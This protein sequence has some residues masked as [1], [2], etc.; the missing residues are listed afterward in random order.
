MLVLLRDLLQQRLVQSDDLK[1]KSLV[2]LTPKERSRSE[3]VFETTG[4]EMASREAAF[5]MLPH[6]ATAR[7]I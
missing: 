2:N 7:R 1:R 5:D 3:T 4:C 6:S